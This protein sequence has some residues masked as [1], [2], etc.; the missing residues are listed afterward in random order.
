MPSFAGMQEPVRARCALR[1]VRCP[2]SR[3][4]IAIHSQVINVV[5][6]PDEK[7]VFA[8]CR[9]SRIL[10]WCVACALSCK[11]VPPAVLSEQPPGPTHARRRRST[12]S[13]E[14][15]RT[16]RGHDGQI[17]AMAASPD[18][19]RLYSS[20][21][22]LSIIEWSV[23]LIRMPLQCTNRLL[24]CREVASGARLRSFETRY[25]VYSLLCASDNRHLFSACG[26]SP[27]TNDLVAA[28]WCVVAWRG[29][30][31]SSRP[32]ALEVR[33]DPAPFCVIA[34]GTWSAGKL[35]SAS[36]DT[37]QELPTWR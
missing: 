37:R 25:R 22:D 28:K 14:L 16:L 13:G 15:V 19:R 17:W 32:P 29:E 4:G 23:G 9:E 31:V 2:L 8:G 36:R 34:A 20:A 6:T 3:C 11:R 33:L 12:A 24:G 21:N 10:Q 5:V 35:C 1:C 27:N 30:L 7:F 26:S 18:S